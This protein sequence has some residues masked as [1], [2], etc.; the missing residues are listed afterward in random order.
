MVN[1][2]ASTTD[3]QDGSNLLVLDDGELAVPERPWAP[4]VLLA[5]QARSDELALAQLQRPFTALATA[6]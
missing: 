4:A 3:S 6:R 1:G 5:M 2:Y